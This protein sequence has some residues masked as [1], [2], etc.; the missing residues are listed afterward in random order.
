MSISQELLVRFTSNLD[1]VYMRVCP[2]TRCCCF[3]SD[4]FMG[5]HTGAPKCIGWFSGKKA[6]KPSKDTT[7]S[8]SWMSSVLHNC[9][10]VVFHSQY[11]SFHVGQCP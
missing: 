7:W 10:P 5:V 6:L 1:S 9:S 8:D 11:P 2:T 4:D 3:Y